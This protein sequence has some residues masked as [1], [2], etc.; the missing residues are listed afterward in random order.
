MPLRPPVSEKDHTQGNEQALIELV[1]YGD[2]QCS[3]CAYAYQLVKDL[4]LEFGNNI[5]FVFRNFPLSKSHPEAKLAAVASEAAGKQGKFWEMHDILFE[6]Q[7]FLYASWLMKYADQIGLDTVRF[8]ADLFDEALIR[9][10]E[11]DFES[12]VR[13]G[14]NRT[15]AFFVNGEYY[16]GNWRE[17]LSPYVKSIIE[18]YTQR[19][20]TSGV[21]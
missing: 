16:N 6:N 19:Q 18:S 2:F 17:G 21:N 9:K 13:S 8:E 10:V 11:D 14:L 15:P 5:K 1:E 3:F 12:G 20:D 4:Q 7:K